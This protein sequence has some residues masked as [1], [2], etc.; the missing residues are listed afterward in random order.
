MSKKQSKK[1]NLIFQANLHFNSFLKDKMK[2]IKMI[3]KLLRRKFADWRKEINELRMTPP[4]LEEALFALLL[5]FSLT[6]SAYLFGINRQMEKERQRALEKKPE[7]IFAKNMNHLVYDYPIKK[8]VPY[9]SQKDRRTAAFLMAIAKKESNW[10]EFHPEKDGRECYNYW[11]YR[12]TYNQ[13]DSGYS[14]F[15]SPEQAVNVVG[16]RIGE[17]IKQEIDT[18]E[19]MKIWKCGQACSL[20][21]EVAVAKWIEDVD[22]YYKKIKKL[23]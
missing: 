16:N 23:Y 15:R 2:K 20:D 13:T 11:G 21:N 9:I 19:E 6:F 10:G 5:V 22:L 7:S 1:N 18:P 3:Q 4:S 8:M 14:C 17:L 12:G